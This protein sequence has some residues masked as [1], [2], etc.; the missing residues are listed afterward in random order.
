M[1]TVLPFG[2]STACFCFT[3]LLKL[4]STGWRSLGLIYIDDGISE[5]R[6]KS[7]AIIRQVPG[8]SWISPKQVSFLAKTVNGSLIKL[9]FALV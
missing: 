6:T 3:K 1:F 8:K 9:A 4:F 7:L 5:H 2:L